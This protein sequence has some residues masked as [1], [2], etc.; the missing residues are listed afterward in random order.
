MNPLTLLVKLLRPTTAPGFLVQTSW[1]ILRLVV[2]TVMMHNGMDKL[3][4]IEGFADAYVAYLGLPFPIFLSYVAAYTELIGAPLVVLGILTR[5]AALGLFGTMAVA[6][7]HHVSVAGLSIPYLELS[8]IYAAV[9]LFFAVNGA[10]LFSFD[11]LFTNI[12][13]QNVLSNREK[14]VMRLEKSLKANTPEKEEAKKEA[15]AS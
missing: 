1:A 2:G 7:Y 14:V 3:A 10:G 13:D 4:D 12:L 15:I 9:F 11:A 5:P 6:C 8:S